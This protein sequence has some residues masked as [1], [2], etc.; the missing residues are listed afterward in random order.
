MEEK[1]NLMIT[2]TSLSLEDAE[3]VRLETFYKF[4]NFT[5]K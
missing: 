4:F 3:I 1:V 5:Q 2:N